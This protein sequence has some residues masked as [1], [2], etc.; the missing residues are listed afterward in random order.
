[1][2]GLATVFALIIAQP[3]AKPGSDLVPVAPGAV[4]VVRAEDR[5]VAWVQYD[6]RESYPAAK[7]IGYLVDAMSRRGWKLM[8]VDGFR[9]FDTFEPPRGF[10]FARLKSSSTSGG[11]VGGYVLPATPTGKGHVWGAWWRDRSGRGAA[12]TV[13]Y[14]CSMELQ[15]LHSVWARVSAEVLGPE[16]APAE[17]ATRKRTQAE[18]CQP[19]DTRS[20]PLHSSCG[21]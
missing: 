20:R 18:P 21:K 3:V 13:E 5:G 16:E 7:T 1:M 6:V 2:D 19:A 14:R 12:M 8:Q 17:E 4:D 10:D 9:T 11:L 15:G